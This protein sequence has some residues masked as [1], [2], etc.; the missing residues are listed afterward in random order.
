MDDGRHVGN[1]AYGPPHYTFFAGG[2]AIVFA[3]FTSRLS[4]NESHIKQRDFM[5]GVTNFMALVAVLIAYA[6]QYERQVGHKDAVVEHVP[7]EHAA[8]QKPKPPSKRWR[9]HRPTKCSTLSR[10]TCTS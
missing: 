10:G 6:L 4:K 9:S 7:V 5:L 3:A 2:V 8:G 1:Q